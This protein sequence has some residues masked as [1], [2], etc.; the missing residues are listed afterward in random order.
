MQYGYW[1]V[2]VIQKHRLPASVRHLVPGAF[3][4][5]LALLTAVAPF[6]GVALAMWLGLLSAYGCCA[7]AASAVSAR[8]FGADL[9]PVLPVV[10]GCYH[11]G[12]GYGFI[13]G[14]WDFW[15][16]GS[17]PGPSFTA[18]SRPAH[19]PADPVDAVRPR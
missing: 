13:R 2:R 8:R 16:R 18:I 10:F 5:A 6:G 15:L 14:L 7:L 17:R 11:I 1:K 12:Y 19:S 4:A 9:L 3:V